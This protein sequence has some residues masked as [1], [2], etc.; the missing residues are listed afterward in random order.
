MTSSP[1][2]DGATRAVVEDPGATAADRRVLRGLDLRG[3]RSARVH[4]L[5]CAATFAALSMT[6]SLLPRSW[7]FQGMVSG[8]TTSTRR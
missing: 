2:V 3:L 4:G 1:R 5:A 6:P 7:L 8:E